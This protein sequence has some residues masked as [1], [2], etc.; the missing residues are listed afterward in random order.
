MS[1]PKILIASMLKPLKDP[2]AFYRLGISLRETNKYRINIIG[3]SLKKE[4]GDKNLK[5]TSLPVRSRKGFSRIFSAFAF[6]RIYRKERPA[7]SIICTWELIPFAVFGKWLYGGKLVYDVQENY[8]QNIKY[9]RT[10]QGVQR[11]FARSLLIAVEQSGKH[12]IDHFIFS[13]QCYIKEKPSF[14]P[15][16]VLENKFHTEQ[17]SLFRQKKLNY[18][19]IHMLI[20]GTITEVYG[21]MEAL[22]WFLELQKK[23][24]EIHLH[25]IGHCPL[26]DFGI[27]LRKEAEGAVN[28]VLELENRPVAYPLILEAYANADLVLLPYMQLPSIREKI[29]SK[30]YECMAIGVPF[31]HSP[32]PLWTSIAEKYQAGLE[33]DFSKR[34]HGG[35]IMAKLLS[36][37]FYIKAFPYEAFWA[38][39]EKAQLQDLVNRLINSKH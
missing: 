27:A 16:T 37:T 26:P 2:R 5:F 25:V 4:F 15:F 1:K 11:V 3:F 24:P 35:E 23:Y 36:T 12:F 39:K 34:D 9:N 8:V 6:F 28:V 20:S 14:L 7:L 17:V 21:T 29:P 10:M 18:P 30:L 13:E 38:H 32:N 22:Q 31:L 33:V 19:G